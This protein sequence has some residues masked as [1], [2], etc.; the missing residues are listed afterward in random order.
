MNQWLF[1]AGLGIV[2]GTHI[3]LLNTQMPAA[4][5]KQHALANLAAVALILASMR[6]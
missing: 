5:Q 3:A 6:M 4:L 1:Y 2:A